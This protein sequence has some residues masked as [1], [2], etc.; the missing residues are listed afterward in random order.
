MCV[1]SVR[2]NMT[3]IDYFLSFPAA[4]RKHH[5]E[6]LLKETI[7]E[8]T[9]IRF[10]IILN[11]FYISPHPFPLSSECCGVAL[12]TYSQS[13]PFTMIWRRYCSCVGICFLS[14]VRWS[15]CPASES[16][17]ELQVVQILPNGSHSP[18]CPGPGWHWQSEATP[19]EEKQD[20]TQ[21]KTQPQ[22]YRV[23]WMSMR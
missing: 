15:R 17:T 1:M 16:A 8:V 21:T 23:A 19:M 13:L 2:L 11:P 14:S 22:I 7:Q 6:W 12:L 3:E 10:W 18:L 20:R 5:E 4:F 9:K